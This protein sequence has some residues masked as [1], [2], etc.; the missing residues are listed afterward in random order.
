MF[1][2]V[3]GGIMMKKCPS[4]NSYNDELNAICEYCGERF[5]DF[6]NENS[7]DENNRRNNNQG[8][9]NDFGQNTYNNRES[10]DMSNYRTT[11]EDKAGVEALVFGILSF[12][13]CPLVFGPLAIYGVMSQEAPWE[14]QGRYW[15]SRHLHMG[16]G[17]FG[18]NVSWVI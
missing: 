10:F 8:Y 15:Y 3:N 9:Y 2:H 1:K 12:F 17:I 5:P 11:E 18:K 4:C 7:F 6:L 14:Q 16:A 13:C